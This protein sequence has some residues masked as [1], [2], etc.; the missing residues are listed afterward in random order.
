MNSALSFQKRWF[1][2]SQWVIL[3][4]TGRHVW[5]SLNV[6]CKNTEDLGTSTDIVFNDNINCI[7]LL[8]WIK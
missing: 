8:L 5:K 3:I 7:L 6:I 1:V 4:L 2:P